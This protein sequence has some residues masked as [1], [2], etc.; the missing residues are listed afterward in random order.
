MWRPSP[1]TILPFQMTKARKATTTTM[2]G[3][4]AAKTSRFSHHSLKTMSLISSKKP[5]EVFFLVT[6]AFLYQKL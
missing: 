6:S 5:V 3:A 2:K 4:K 1:R